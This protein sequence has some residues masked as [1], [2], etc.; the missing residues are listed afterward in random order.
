MEAGL[1]LL[2]GFDALDD[3]DHAAMRDSINEAFFDGHGNS[4]NS[5][6]TS[7]IVTQPFIQVVRRCLSPAPR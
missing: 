4:T 1:T 3:K 7:S 5:Q 2:E 6:R